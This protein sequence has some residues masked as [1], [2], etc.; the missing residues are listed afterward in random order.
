MMQWKIWRSIDSDFSPEPSSELADETCHADEVYTDEVLQQIAEN[1]FNG[2]WVHALLHHI[3]CAAPFEPLS[4]QSAVHQQHLH[5]LCGRAAK[6][7][8]KVFLYIQPLRAVPLKEQ[9]FWSQFKEICGGSEYPEARSL[10]ISTTIVRKWLEDLSKDFA[11]KLPELGGVLLITASELPAHCYSHWQRKDERWGLCCPRC[12]EREPEEIVVDQLLAVRNGIRKGGSDM[13]IAAWDWSWGLWHGKAPYHAIQDSLP[14]DITILADFERGGFMDFQ[15]RPH[16]KVD[17]YCLTFAGPSD[18]CRSVI[19]CAQERSAQT[20]VKLQL[21]TTHELASVVSLPLIT[22]I[23]KKIAACKEMKIDGFMG[24]WN[25]GNFFSANTAAVQFFLS[26]GCLADETSAVKQFFNRYFGEECDTE[27]ALIA[28]RELA[29]AMTFFP[30]CILFIYNAPT[31]YALAYCEVFR[32]G[33]LS[34]KL[35]GP[36]HLDIPERGDSFDAV[37]DWDRCGLQAKD[38]FTLD[39]ILDMLPRLVDAWNRAAKTF[40]EAFPQ[41]P[42]NRAALEIN[43]M[44]LIGK[45]WE[46]VLHAFQAY[47]MR[48]VWSDEKLPLLQKIIKEEIK[49]IRT[50]LP[51]V[52]MDPRQGWHG[53]AHQYLFSTEKISSK[54]RFLCGLIEKQAQETILS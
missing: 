3:A 8:I 41:E 43:N 2:I 53:E 50:A 38:V 9:A 22:N 29:C 19:A 47:A 7:G 13:V 18:D 10:C 23:Y 25:F 12:G 54:I 16:Q 5:T 14:G 30:F 36:S 49:L 39:E 44:L 26:E 6:Y 45:V 40:A 33:P 46:S 48:K 34:G 52:E 11:R 15:H 27:K 32:P 1:G 4:R 28:C 20:M 31:N 35:C 37:F 17:E 42:G 24:C 21:G 51:L